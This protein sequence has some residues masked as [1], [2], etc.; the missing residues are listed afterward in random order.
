MK[1]AVVK[2]KKDGTPSK[3]G[4]GG[5]NPPKYATEEDL[6]LAGL[7]YFAEIKQDKK[8]IATKAGLC[9]ALNISRDT[10]S[11]YRKKY[12][13]TIRAFDMRMENAW[14]ERLAGNGATGAIFYLKNAFRDHYKDRIETDITSKGEQIHIYIPERK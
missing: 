5:G 4:E 8:R 12:P 2:K 9:L 6:L 14:T 3:Q 11:E 1:K 7:S 13:D 10:Y